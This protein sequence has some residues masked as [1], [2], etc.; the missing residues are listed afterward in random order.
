MKNSYYLG[1]RPR[2]FCAL[3]VLGR[4]FLS[5]KN[6]TRDDN[7]IMIIDDIKGSREIL[8]LQRYPEVLLSFHFD[9]VYF[10]F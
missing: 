2:P 8:V 4:G 9:I 10:A 5:S 1:Q 3:T 7:T 6:L